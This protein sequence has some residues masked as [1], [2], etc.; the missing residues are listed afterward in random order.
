MKTI[1]IDGWL[2]FLPDSTQKITT[3]SNDLYRI[4]AAISAAGGNVRSHDLMRFLGLSRLEPYECRIKLLV[5]AG[6]LQ[7]E[8]RAKSSLESLVA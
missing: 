5:K 6:Y 8:S 7:P 4:I 1:R 2:Y 3:A